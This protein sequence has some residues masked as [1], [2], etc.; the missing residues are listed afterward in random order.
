MLSSHAAYKLK[1]CHFTVETNTHAS[2]QS[3][4]LDF[5]SQNISLERPQN[6]EKLEC[7]AQTLSP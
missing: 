7:A 3:S 5:Y 2:F 6:L 4:V 1:L